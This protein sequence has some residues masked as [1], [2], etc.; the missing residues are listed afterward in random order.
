MTQTS[1]QKRENQYEEEK[2]S[3]TRTSTKKTNKLL[4]IGGPA[5]GK[6]LEETEFR[7]M[8]YAQVKP[9][10]WQLWQE[11]IIDDPQD[12]GYISHVYNVQELVFQDNKESRPYFKKIYLH[13]SLTIE[14]GMERLKAFLV[15]Q[16]I[17][18]D[19]S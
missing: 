11:D 8:V 17:K 7:S 16:F 13:S 3:G 12:L 6:M 15:E 1:L 5:E 4:V 14:A 9:V 19:L 2:V 10:S 18:M